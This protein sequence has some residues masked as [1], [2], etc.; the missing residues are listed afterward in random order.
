MTFK[1][2]VKMDNQ[3]FEFPCFELVRILREFCDNI[4]G[5]EIDNG[6]DWSLRD[7]NG[8]NVGFAKV[9]K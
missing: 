2:S 8:N 4:E 6:D 5:G 1:L 7:V 3:A 9:T